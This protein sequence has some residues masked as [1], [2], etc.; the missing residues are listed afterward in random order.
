MGKAWNGSLS[1][2]LRKSYLD[3]RIPGTKMMNPRTPEGPYP[4][5]TSPKLPPPHTPKVT[6]S[7]HPQSYFLDANAK[8][9]VDARRKIKRSYGRGR[10]TK[11]IYRIEI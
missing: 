8:N 3:S 11:N 10:R 7:P 2:T 4:L 5:P 1:R 6:P 9:C